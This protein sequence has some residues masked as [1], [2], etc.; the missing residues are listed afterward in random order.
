MDIKDILKTTQEGGPTEEEVQAYMKKNKIGSLE[1]LVKLK[2]KSGNVIGRI[3]DKQKKMSGK[4]KA[5][6]GSVKK[7][8]KGGSV[9]KAK[10]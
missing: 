3:M 10:Y 1:E 4:N 2:S 5:H 8:A 7:Y 9:R 6:G